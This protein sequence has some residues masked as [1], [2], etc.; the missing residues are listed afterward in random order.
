[1]RRLIVAVMLML[2]VTGCTM[3]FPIVIE[4]AFPAIEWSG[5]VTDTPTISPTSTATGT[6]QATQTASPTVTNTVT[7]SPTF[8]PTETA[9]I[10]PTIDPSPTRENVNRVQVE[11]TVN[12]RQSPDGAIIGSAP[13]GTIFEVFAQR[14][15]NSTLCPDVWLDTG[16]GWICNGS[17]VEF[18]SG[19]LGNVP[20]SQAQAQ[21]RIGYNTLEVFDEDYYL[22]HARALCPAY[23][24]VMDNLALA[25]RVYEELNPLCG[26]QVIHRD[27]HPTDGDEF[28][29]RS[30]QEFVLQWER[31]GHK[32]II[33][34][35]TNEPS[36]GG[37][38][39]CSVLVAH[40]VE[41]ARLA[42]DAGF[43]V[44]LG[45]FGV[46]K[47]STE[48]V[49]AGVYNPLIQ[50]I[51][52]YGHIFGAHEYTWGCL[53]FGFG[54]MPTDFFF[55]P[56]LM[57]AEQ[58][59]TIPSFDALVCGTL[60]P[61]WHMGRSFMILHQAE[62]DLGI[63]AS[64]ITVVHTEWGWDYMGDIDPVIQ[65]LRQD[66]AHPQ[67]EFNLRG[68]RSLEFLWQFWWDDSSMAESAYLQMEW[69]IAQYPD[70]HYFLLFAWSDD[71]NRDWTR[72]GFSFGNYGDGVTIELHQLLAAP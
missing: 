47:Y 37:G 8:V 13:A 17:W 29:V 9:T 33:R 50:A 52:D 71:P 49:K 69:A 30:P 34:Y 19:S 43:T 27:W 4:F 1:M 53:C 64:Q 58:W 15:T 48:D 60:P 45:N 41:L 59:I 44:V 10:T 39:P 16:N 66:F 63:D 68:W 62:C 24:L 36:C 40:E 51:V 32:H 46:G 57:Q 35:A 25:V 55:S 61:Y 54:Q 56:G 7:V 18:I 11:F 31:Q 38:T 65:A 21:G 67:Y 5:D 72:A 42:R 23:M 70:N 12:I 28:Q 22:A 14:D 3:R 26:T 6:P 2:F 20:V